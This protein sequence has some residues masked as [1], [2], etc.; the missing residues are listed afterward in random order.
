MQNILEP[1]SHRIDKLASISIN[2]LLARPLMSLMNALGVFNNRNDSR[3]ERS[4]RTEYL[5]TTVG[6]VLLLC[7]PPLY[8]LIAGRVFNPIGLKKSVGW[9]LSLM[10][11]DFIS[12]NGMSIAVA[13]AY[14]PWVWIAAAVPGCLLGLAYWVANRPNRQQAL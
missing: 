8:I 6:A 1:V 11:V 5:I 10:F 14:G 3:Q 2:Y 12:F 4:M 9:L 7:A 13:E